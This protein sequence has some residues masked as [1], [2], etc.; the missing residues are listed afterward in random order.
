M[1]D[2][3]NL[4]NLALI[5]TLVQSQSTMSLGLIPNTTS[6]ENQIETRI[7]SLHFPA[8]RNQSSFFSTIITQD[9]FS[10][11]KEKFDI[12]GD[13]PIKNNSDLY[14]FEISQAIGKGSKGV[15]YKAVDI[16]TK[17]EYALKFLE[18][19]SF[20]DN[21]YLNSSRELL[22][23]QILNKVYENRIETSNF[24]KLSD[25][26][27]DD[28]E[29]LSSRLYLVIVME[30]CI[31]DLNDVLN[32]RKDFG[33]NFSE[34]ELLFILNELIQALLQLK[35]LGIA[36]R[37][38]KLDNILYNSCTS[39]LKLADFS[40]SKII[41]INGND[42]ITVFEN[43]IKGSEAYMSPEILLVYQMHKKQVKYLYDPWKA[44]IYSVGLCIYVLY[45]KDKMVLLD[46]KAIEN[47]ILFWKGKSAENLSVIQQILI[48]LLEK[49]PEKRVSFETMDKALKGDERIM[50]GRELFAIRNKD[51]VD[52]AFSQQISPNETLL[53]SIKKMIG[54]AEIYSRV[55]QKDKAVNKYHEIIHFLTDFE[56]LKVSHE[57]LKIVREMLYLQAKVYDNLGS[58]F[59]KSLEY[60][61]AMYNFKE[62][63][64]LLK[65]L[66]KS[67]QNEFMNHEYEQLVDRN[68]INLALS[69]QYSFQYNEALTLLSKIQEKFNQKL[70]KILNEQL[71]EEIRKNKLRSIFMNISEIYDS[72]GG[73][74]RALK[75]P[76]KS[77]E[78]HQKALETS[79]FLNDQDLLKLKSYKGH[80][81][82][83]L[84]ELNE[85]DDA[86]NLLQNKL[87]FNKKNRIYYSDD[88]FYCLVQ[89]SK[90][91][92]SQRLWRDLDKAEKVLYEALDILKKIYK[93]DKNPKFSF[94]YV[95]LGKINKMQGNMKKAEEFYKKAIEINKITIGEDH[96]NYIYALLKLA[97]FYK[98]DKREGKAIDVYEDIYKKFLTNQSFIK[99]QLDVFCDVCLCLGEL[100]MRGGDDDDQSYIRLNE[101]YDFLNEKKDKNDLLIRNLILL[102]ENLMINRDFE[103]RYKVKNIK[104][105]YNQ[106]NKLNR[107][108]KYNIY[109][110]RLKKISDYLYRK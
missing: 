77:K 64:K 25:F 98:Y 90:I 7:E 31:L 34:N 52:L 36:H 20:S 24:L 96:Y 102:C 67:H 54:T 30:F 46:R 100:Y 75:N 9:K 73:I 57:D 10:S 72:Q 60:E 69:L 89:M 42:N 44:D 79:D 43:T 66:E 6:T 33:E 53:E 101:S 63:E 14:N 15:I 104:K 32:H 76:Q 39:I 27:F 56:N 85:F 70:I 74:Y 109:N 106:A 82:K 87:D 17:Q 26:Y 78:F 38:V 81:A 86:F 19:E 40:E 80:L 95:E 99:S 18:F 71:D 103:H 51:I 22:I 5:A 48:D 108:N 50:K 21:N 12:V 29:N 62:A 41:E 61:P 4:D 45:K 110:F 35:N 84:I 58:I 94:P 2:D 49:D 23:L 8:L 55:F 28:T 88:T 65:E 16:Y 37:D 91:Y 13:I 11:L 3:I 1:S 83:V 47:E 93:N 92:S 68:S 59:L 105:Y 107:K 97:K